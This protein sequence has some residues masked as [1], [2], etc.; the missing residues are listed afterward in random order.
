MKS[1]A[2]FP[3]KSQKANIFSLKCNIC[4]PLAPLCPMVSLKKVVA[5]LARIKNIPTFAAAFKKK[6]SYQSGQ[7]GLTVTQLAYAFGGSNPSLPTENKRHLFYGGGVFFI[8]SASHKLLCKFHSSRLRWPTKRQSLP[9]R[10]P[11]II[12]TVISP[13]PTCAV[14]AFSTIAAMPWLRAFC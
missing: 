8:G 10:S 7:M 3:Y 13:L 1:T 11:A 2:P 6:G 12:R 9:S 5:T 4:R 14:G